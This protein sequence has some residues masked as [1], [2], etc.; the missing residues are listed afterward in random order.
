M[1]KKMINVYI[2]IVWPY[3]QN[4]S[5]SPLQCTHFFSQDH[6]HANFDHLEKKKKKQPNRNQLKVKRQLN[7]AGF[8]F[9]SLFLFQNQFNMNAMHHS[10]SLSG[11]GT[12]R[13][14]LRHSETALTEFVSMNKIWHHK[15]QI[16]VEILSFEIQDDPAGHTFYIHTVRHFWG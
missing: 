16:L 2:R 14:K 7:Y 3:Q 15:F 9:L 1:F 13:K 10:S 6:I 5:Y 4:L 11:K 8:F 12:E